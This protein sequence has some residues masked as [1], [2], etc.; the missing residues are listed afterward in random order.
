MRAQVDRI[1]DALGVTPEGKIHWNGNPLLYEELDVAARTGKRAQWLRQGNAFTICIDRILD[2]LPRPRPKPDAWRSARQLIGEERANSVSSEIVAFLESIPRRYDFSFPLSTSHPIGTDTV[3]L[4][5]NVH[6]VTITET[7]PAPEVGGSLLSGLL[8][9]VAAP[10]TDPPTEIRRVVVRFRVPGYFDGS[11][12]NPTVRFAL[13]LLRQFA[14]LALAA[15]YMG[16]KKRRGVLAL[17][18]KATVSDA[19]D[20]GDIHN[21]ETPEVVANLFDV[22]HLS[23]SAITADLSSKVENLPIDQLLGD[24]PVSA[25]WRPKILHEKFSPIMQAMHPHSKDR[26]SLRTA[27]EWLFDSHAEQN[28]TAALLFGSIGLEAVLESP[29]NDVTERLADRLAWLLGKTPAERKK[30]QGEYKAFY[31]VRSAL[32]HGRHRSI[33]PAGRAKLQWARTTLASVIERELEHCRQA[34]PDAES[35]GP[36]VDLQ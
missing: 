11:P 16:F 2:T 35:I 7:G 1:F 36:E 34:G 29:I 10:A 5:R 31:G 14:G 23:E 8:A 24:E 30:L 33:D 19:T 26:E 28:E 12:E 6:L 22:L 13:S 25:E 15:G 27:A 18:P 21:F 3:E 20:G 4:A 9:E 17:R 32:I